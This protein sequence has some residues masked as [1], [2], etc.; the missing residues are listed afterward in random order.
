MVFGK[1]SYIELIKLMSDVPATV[2]SFRDVTHHP[3]Y[4]YVEHYQSQDIF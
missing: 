4:G 3:M 1:L 2:P